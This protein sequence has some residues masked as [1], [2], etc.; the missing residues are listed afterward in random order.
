MPSKGTYK[1]SGKQKHVQTQ[2]TL[3]KGSH[4]FMPHN[5]SNEFSP[6]ESSIFSLTFLSC[7]TGF[8]TFCLLDDGD[9]VRF[10]LLDNGDF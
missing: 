5:Y 8:V 4:H 6:Y 9:L 7:V 1:K 10:C 2:D 3:C